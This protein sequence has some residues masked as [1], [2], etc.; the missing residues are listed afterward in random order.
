MWHAVTLAPDRRSALAGA[1]RRFV[2]TPEA[3]QAIVAQPG[4]VP[5]ERFRPAVH[6]TIWTA[7]E[8]GRR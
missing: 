6:T 1:L 2:T 4:G 8:P 3:T 7:L 5:A